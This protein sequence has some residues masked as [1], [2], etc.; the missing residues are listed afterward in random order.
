MSVLYGANTI[1]LSTPS[2]KIIDRILQEDSSTAAFQWC[3]ADLDRDSIAEH[4]S[5]QAREQRHG[6]HTYA[7]F[8]DLHIFSKRADVCVLL[9][10]LLITFS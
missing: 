8:V 9:Y 5:F 10:M 2:S 7:S 3:W 6:P 4:T 1:I